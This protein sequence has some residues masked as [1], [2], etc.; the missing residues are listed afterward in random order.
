MVCRTKFINWRER[1]RLIFIFGGPCGRSICT[2]NQTGT[3]LFTAEGEGLH[4]RE[5]P[6]GKRRFSLSS[7]GEINLIVT[8]PSSAFFATV[9]DTHFTVRN[10]ANGMPL[11]EFPATTAAAFTANGRYLLTRIDD[12]SAAWWTWRSSDLRKEACAR[13]TSNL[14]RE[15]SRWLPNQ[16]YR[17]TCP[18]PP[19]GP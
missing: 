15:W 12:R 3:M 13:L 4:A 8:D 2:L 6:S 19:A 17:L 14:S 5:I 18:N 9:T 11:A 16:A 1:V 7:D 10:T